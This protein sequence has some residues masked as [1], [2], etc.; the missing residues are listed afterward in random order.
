MIGLDT[1]FILTVEG[2]LDSFKALM[3][4]YTYSSLYH[5]SIRKWSFT[6]QI[7]QACILYSDF[8]QEPK[9]GRDTNRTQKNKESTIARIIIQHQV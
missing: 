8:G 4:I 1:Q 6:Y 7:I 9:G 3:T 2:G 5:H